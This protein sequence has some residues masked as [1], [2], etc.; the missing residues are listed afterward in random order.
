LIL[1]FSIVNKSSETITIELNY[2][3]VE[4]IGHYKLK[5][6][7]EAKYQEDELVSKS[8]ENG[9]QIEVNENTTTAETVC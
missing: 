5:D 8:I 3:D 1:D 9:H 4:G 7:I 2:S 6:V